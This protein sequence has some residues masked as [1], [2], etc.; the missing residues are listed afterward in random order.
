MQT[1]D[2]EKKSMYT[3]TLFNGKSM[4]KWDKEQTLNGGGG[5]G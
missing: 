3:Y 1:E 5:G 2:R 4:I